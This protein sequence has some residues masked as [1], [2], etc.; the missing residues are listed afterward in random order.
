MQMIIQPQHAVTPEPMKLLKARKGQEYHQRINVIPLPWTVLCQRHGCP[1]DIPAHSTCF[2]DIVGSIS[3][4]FLAVARV[5][6][7]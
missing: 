2:S 5:K 3:S 6:L 4:L 7:S 1:I